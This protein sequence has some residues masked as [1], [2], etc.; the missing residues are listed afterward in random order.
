MSAVHEAMTRRDTPRRSVLLGMCLL[1]GAGAMDVRPTATATGAAAAGAMFITRGELSSKPMSGAGWEML[2][3]TADMASYGVVDLGDINSLTQSY[4]LAGALVYARTGDSIYRDK[5]IAAVRQTCGT[6]ADGPDDLLALARTLYGYVV[7]ADLVEMPYSTR[8]TNGQTWREFLEEVRTEVIPGHPRWKT[9]EFTSANT[10]SNWGAYALSSHLAVS[11]ALDDTDAIQRDIDIFKR[12]LGDLTSP[13][14]PFVPSANYLLNG[15]GDTWDMTPVLQRGINPYSA[16]DPRQG[17]LIEDALRLSSGGE[18]SVECCRVQPAAIAYQEEALDG[19]LSTA[20]LLRAHGIDLRSFQHNAMCRAFE[21][22]IANGGPGPYSVS[23][24]IPYA[25]NY[26]YRT[27]Y[28][29]QTE[30]QPYR[31]MGYGAWLF[32]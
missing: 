22:L 23:R 19:I 29:T 31:H 26:L 4:V 5:V 9:L 20:Q 28:P 1:V 10:S 14:A 11:Y 13:A 18:D 27:D 30:D 16:T 32:T 17:A 2:Q 15:N 25:I 8:C 7:A 3:S 21:F 24:Y 6:E 12:F